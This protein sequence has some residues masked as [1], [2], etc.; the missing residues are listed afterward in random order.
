[1]NG[2]FSNDRPL[3]KA[4][5]YSESDGEGYAQIKHY[6]LEIRKFEGHTIKSSAIKPKRTSSSFIHKSSP[7][8]KG[9][10]RTTVLKTKRL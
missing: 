4:Q 2:G 8:K 9:S 1:M 10:F 3:K 7:L 5:G 6:A